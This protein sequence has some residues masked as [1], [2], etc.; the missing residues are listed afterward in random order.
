MKRD[1]VKEEEVWSREQVQRGNPGPRQ[2]CG[3]R[4]ETELLEDSGG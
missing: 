4:I 3:N 1:Q 2:V